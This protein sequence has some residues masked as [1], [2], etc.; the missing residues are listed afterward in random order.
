MPA[1]NVLQTALPQQTTT[2]G[3][4]DFCVA[5]ICG[6]GSTRLYLAA[7]IF[8][9]GAIFVPASRTAQA[10]VES[11]FSGDGDATQTESFLSQASIE[12]ESLPDQPRFLQRRSAIFGFLG[13]T[14]GESTKHTEG[15]DDILGDVDGAVV[16]PPGEN[17]ANSKASA[18]DDSFEKHR[19]ADYATRDKNSD[20]PDE[21]NSK[22]TW[23]QDG[24]TPVGDEANARINEAST[25]PDSIAQDTLN[26]E[27]G[28]EAVV[29]DE[30]AEQEADHALGNTSLTGTEEP[31]IAAL[32]AFNSEA[33]DVPETRERQHEERD[34]QP[35]IPETHEQKQ[36]AM[37]VGTY[38]EEEVDDEVQNTDRSKQASVEQ[39][40][41]VPDE[42][43]TM[44]E[45]TEP[46]ADHPEQNESQAQLSETESG[47]Q[48][49][50]I[51]DTMLTDAW[52][53]MPGVDAMKGVEDVT[54]NVPETKVDLDRAQNAEH[55]DDKTGSL[56]D[57]EQS[58]DVQPNKPGEGDSLATVVSLAGMSGSAPAENATD[59]SRVAQH[60]QSKESVETLV[61]FTTDKLDRENQEDE[62]GRPDS[63]H[64]YWNAGS[65]TEPIAAAG[66]LPRKHPRGQYAEELGVSTGE[67][68][69]IDD[70]AGQPVMLN[71]TEQEKPLNAY[72]EVNFSIPD[73]ATLQAEVENGTV[74]SSM[75]WKE[76]SSEE[77]EFLPRSTCHGYCLAGAKRSDNQGTTVDTPNRNDTTEQLQQIND[78]QAAVTPISEK[79]VR[80]MLEASSKVGGQPSL[81]SVRLDH[82]LTHTPEMTKATEG[83]ASRGHLSAKPAASRTR[84]PPPPKQSQQQQSAIQDVSSTAEPQQQTSQ[85]QS[86]NP[87]G[88]MSFLPTRD[89][90]SL[91]TAAQTLELKPLLDLGKTMTAGIGV[92][93]AAVTASEQQAEAS[94]LHQHLEQSISL[95]EDYIRKYLPEM[96]SGGS[97]RFQKGWRVLPFSDILGQE[98]YDRDD[99]VDLGSTD[100]VDL[101]D[102]DVQ[103][104][105][106]DELSGTLRSRLAQLGVFNQATQLTI[107]KLVPTNSTN[108]PAIINSLVQSNSSSSGHSVANSSIL[109]PFG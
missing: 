7:V 79:N 71:T 98:R 33:A 2:A 93:A 108:I 30:S 35:R 104:P 13:R 107:P 109:W 11:R 3:M 12:D 49:H 96:G 24:N 5:K 29:K 16:T 83:K 59:E 62:I 64:K 54:P 40:Q 91:L 99:A 50:S 28:H 101:V 51:I 84:N 44:E 74:S 15:T 34:E 45:H 52:E 102:N 68:Y 81:A 69:D 65:L 22:A 60:L 72:V 19:S 31:V 87:A 17:L 25:T 38:R 63:I 8:V 58:T 6:A 53:V 27:R 61:M 9:I 75:Q 103:D 56:V 55:Q 76:P 92:G 97:N 94:R 67:W 10:S 48:N 32:T 20:M 46:E 105:V 42:F 57:N 4:A 1:G 78:Q 23:Q 85:Q 37:V 80:D 73:Q 66:D 36:E 39:D 21:T 88:L 95:A 77:V 47:N 18:D 26:H 106:T 41:V 100:Y 14:D 82:V 90:L 89:I 70:T 86:M 43:A